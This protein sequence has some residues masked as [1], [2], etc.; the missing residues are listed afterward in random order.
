MNIVKLAAAALLSALAPAAA[1]AQ[2][3]FY[4]TQASYNAAVAGST[5]TNF[6]FGN[7]GNAPSY[8]VGNLTFASPGTVFTSAA[9][10][11][12]DFG[13][14]AY[15]GMQDAAG[16]PGTL[17][18]VTVSGGNTRGVSFTLG[19]IYGSYVTT[20]TVNG[21]STPVTVP[22]DPSSAFF[23]VTSSTP[24]TSISFTLDNGEIDFLNGFTT[25]TSLASAAP[26]PG[27]WALMIG[28]FG[29]TGWA[30]RRKRRKLALAPA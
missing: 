29:A 21:S 25:A 22:G 23:G 26:E 2:V 24:I 16:V 8:T 19:D 6:T 7:T 5:T 4:T 30:L 1:Q 13:G 18:T 10:P 9:V 11:G 12:G 27:S 3:T 20:V 14:S 28:G 17:G 15:I